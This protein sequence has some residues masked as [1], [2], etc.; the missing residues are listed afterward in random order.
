MKPILCSGSRCLISRRNPLRSVGDVSLHTLAAPL[1]AQRY[2][3]DGVAAVFEEL[4]GDHDR[5]WQADAG[6]D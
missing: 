1:R 6:T 2:V 4:R 3:D 5:A